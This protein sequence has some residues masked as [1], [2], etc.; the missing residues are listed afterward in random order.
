MESALIES[1]IG[2][3]W[4]NKSLTQSNYDEFGNG[5]NVSYYAWSGDSWV[6]NLDGLLPLTYNYN[7]K[8]EYFNGSYLLAHYNSLPVGL[9]DVAAFDKPQLVCQPNPAHDIT[10]ISLTIPR[11][12]T[13]QLSLYSIDGSK[14]MT[15]ADCPF[16]KGK[17]QVQ[18]TTNTLTS[19][20][21]FV[22]YRTINENINY[23]LI[24]N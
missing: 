19:G 13:A 2:G 5:K 7:S 11:E 4:E 17:Q 1:W 23:K 8:S 15:I 16:T 20:I 24:I 14:L 18:F 9:E 6:L 12:T 10:T 22:N 3:T 21:Y